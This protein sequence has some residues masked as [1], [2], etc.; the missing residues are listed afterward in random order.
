M[1]SHCWVEFFIQI[2]SVINLNSKVLLTPKNFSKNKIGPDKALHNLT[3]RLE[4]YDNRND[5]KD[6]IERASVRSKT[7]KR[8]RDNLF[9][10]SRNK[11]QFLWN[12]QSTSGTNSY[13]RENSITNSAMPTAKK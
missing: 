5:S 4:K 2:I 3:E 11:D 8:P 6:K 10:S 7:N 12:N 9:A 13:I 1:K